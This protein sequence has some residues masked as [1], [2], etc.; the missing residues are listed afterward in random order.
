MGMNDYNIS[1]QSQETLFANHCRC[2]MASLLSSLECLFL[3]GHAGG[4][5]R[6]FNMVQLPPRTVTPCDTPKNNTIL[7]AKQLFTI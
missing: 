2:F 1:P 6:G 7:G 4:V 3:R 5:S